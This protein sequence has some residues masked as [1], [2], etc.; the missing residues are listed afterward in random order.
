MVPALKK[1]Y[2]MQ[3][4][5]QP[6][7]NIC[8]GITTT[9]FRQHAA[10]PTIA[11]VASPFI[12][13]PPRKYGGTELF[14]AHLAIALHKAG[15][16]VVVYANGESRLPGIEIRSK[17]AKSEWPLNGGLSESLKNADHVA[18]AIRDASRSCDII[19]L[20]D[21]VGLCECFSDLPLVYT[22]HHPHTPELTLHYRKFPEAPKFC[23]NQ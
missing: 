10:Y 6:P 23:G 14:I 21:A 11:L 9:H 22:I 13:V 8:L 17:Y 7:S 5:A 2:P 3:Q 4:A 18:W 12:S 19:H 15:A 20:N 1:G 16:R